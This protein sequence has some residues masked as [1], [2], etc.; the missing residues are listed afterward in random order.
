MT[1]IKKI[2]REQKIMKI[3]KRGYP[4]DAMTQQLLWNNYKYEN[5]KFRFDR[6]CLK[7]QHFQPHPA[8]H[9]WYLIFNSNELESFMMNWRELQGIFLQLQHGSWHLLL[10]S[11]M[12]WKINDLSEA[13]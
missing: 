12:N 3:W 1:R 11:I 5:C 9:Q 13:K 4:S 7:V 2:E 6:A 8:E 10:R